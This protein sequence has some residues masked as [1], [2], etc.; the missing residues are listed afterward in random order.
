MEKVDLEYIRER[1]LR[2]QKNGEKDIFLCN[3]VFSDRNLRHIR[4]SQFEKFLI[5]N[6][7]KEGF[8]T[9][10]HQFKRQGGVAFNTDKE[11]LE[12][13]ELQINKTN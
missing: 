8:Y 4:H 11:R 7:P 9:P 12:W 3:L 10:L 2:E 5:D 1:F 6:Y 13:L